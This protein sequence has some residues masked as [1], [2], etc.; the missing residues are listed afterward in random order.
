VNRSEFQEH[1]ELMTI[2]VVVM[3]ALLFELELIG[4]EVKLQLI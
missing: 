2:A 3:K 1:V 4:K